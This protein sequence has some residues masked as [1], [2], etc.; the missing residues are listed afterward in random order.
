MHVSRYN[1]AIEMRSNRD[2]QPAEPRSV[3]TEPPV[4]S[5]R[6]VPKSRFH[7]FGPERHIGCSVSFIFYYN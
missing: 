1:S 2:D 4:R 5:T 7:K 3:R 6:Y